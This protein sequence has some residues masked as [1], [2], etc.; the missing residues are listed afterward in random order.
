MAKIH[1]DYEYS[2]KEAKKLIEDIEK[3]PLSECFVRVLIH[4]KQI[5]AIRRMG[6]VFISTASLIKYI[7]LRQIS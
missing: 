3:K 1:N 2:P 4:R 5:K 6:R 7:R